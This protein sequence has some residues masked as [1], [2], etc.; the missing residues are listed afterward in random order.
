MISPCRA[1]VLP[2]L[3]P[4]RR[5]FTLVE[6]LV[7]VT[8]AT[9]LVGLL[10]S[11][12][13]RSLQLSQ[14]SA[15]AMSAYSS[16][17]TAVNLVATDLASL[18]VTSQ[19]FEYLQAVPESNTSNPSLASIPSPNVPPMRLMMLVTSPEDSAQ[20]SPSGSNTYPDSA[21]VRAVSYLMAWQ[22]PVS[23]TAGS[24]A[25]NSA[26]GLYRQVATTADTFKSVLG[27]TDLYQ[28]LYPSIFQ[29]PPAISTLVTGNIVDFQLAFYANQISPGGGGYPAVGS[30]IQPPAII[31][32][33]SLP[34]QKTQL[35]G[36]QVLVNG[37]APTLNGSPCGPVVYAEVSLTVIED[38]GAKL[39]G[40]GTGTGT[41]SPA[42][43]KRKYGH[44]L[45]RK[46]LLRTPE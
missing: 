42:A 20:A 45:T 12:M 40:D 43:L 44:T 21:Q 23:S 36:T 37:A 15:E 27:S 19:P 35:Q 25:G 6:L 33:A 8:V 29:A 9:L 17:A 22:N 18:S 24:N 32:S 26:F 1:E 4:A 41:R 46:V 16:A 30:L 39:W 28:T 2:P 14:S 34:Y 38:T 7:S 13:V 31:N 5:G 11:V 3:K 10:T